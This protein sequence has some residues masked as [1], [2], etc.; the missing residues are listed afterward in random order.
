M[1]LC[2]EQKCKQMKTCLRFYLG[3]FKV[4]TFALTALYTL[5]LYILGH[6]HEVVTTNGFPTLEG[7]P[8][9]RFLA[10]FSCVPTDLNH[11]TGFGSGDC[12]GQVM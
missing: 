12:V 6:I 4:G 11:L 8:V 1:E 2:G 3:F 10:A 7:V 5:L 9:R